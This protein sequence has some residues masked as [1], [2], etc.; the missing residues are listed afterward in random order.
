MRRPLNL[1]IAVAC[2]ALAAATLGFRGG[3]P[4]I[5][6]AQSC[7]GCTDFIQGEAPHNKA[8]ASNSACF[9]QSIGTA[10]AK[11]NEGSIS[12]SAGACGNDPL[13]NPP[14]MCFDPLGNCFVFQEIG[15]VA[16]SNR[17]K[18]TIST[19]TGQTIGLDQLVG[20]I[21]G[22]GM[23]DGVTGS[24]S[25]NTLVLKNAGDDTPLL[26]SMNNPGGC[27]PAS[28]EFCGQL[29]AGG[30][31][32]KLTW[33]K[34]HGDSQ[35]IVF[36]DV[37]GGKGANN[38]TETLQGGH[39]VQWITNGTNPDFITAAET[40]FFEPKDGG[41]LGLNA[42]RNKLNFVGS[43]SVQIVQNGNKNTLNGTGNFIN[44]TV[45]NGSNN[46]VNVKGNSDTVT[47]NGL[48]TT[49]TADGNS[50][51][52]NGNYDMVTLIGL[53]DQH[54]VING[55]GIVCDSQATC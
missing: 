28:G 2:A 46:T 6:H 52:I 25:N 24:S 43:N 16:G 40:G 33:T 27:G 10:G 11:G 45:L 4:V 17:N 48:S 51:T 1:A 34:S 44:E 47:I 26:L 49:S 39:N 37:T 30:N 18:G 21:A 14:G 12:T 54:I 13:F 50:V 20:S 3:G 9:F 22:N 19:S 7:S 29:V 38:N 41:T 32:N 35:E 5:A 42:S 8:K 55:N 31:S 36:F 23:F 53:S 15:T